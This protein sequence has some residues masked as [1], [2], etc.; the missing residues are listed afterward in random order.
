[1]I[2]AHDMKDKIVSY[3]KA[4]SGKTPAYAE[5]ADL[6]RALSRVVMESLAE[7]WERAEIQ[8]KQGRQAHYFSIEFLTGRSL[9]NNL[10]NLGLYETAAYAV[11]ELGF[12]LGDLIEQ[13]ADPGLGNG[14][15]GR[16]AACF[17]DSCAAGSLPVRGYGILY[18]YGLFRQAIENGFQKEYPDAWMEQP[19]PFLVC[20]NQQKVLVRY[21]DLDVFAVPYDL[22]ITGYRSDRVNTLRLWKAEPILPFDFELFNAQRFDEAVK[23]RNRVQDIC[24][25]LY[26]NDTTFEG[27]LLRVRQQYFFVSASI[28][29]IVNDFIT[30]HGKDFDRF[31][32]YN[33][34]QLNDTHPVLAIPELM[35]ILID[36]EHLNWDQAWRIT[37]KVFAYTNHTIMQE[38]L[39]KW[40]VQIFKCLF[41]RILEII[42]QIDQQFRKDAKQ[43]GLSEDQIQCL[44]PQNDGK[45]QM[46]S[47]A[48][49]G[50]YSVNGVA[51]MHTRI[52]KQQTL[53]GFYQLWPERFN[54][55]TNGVTPRRWLRVC[56]PELSDLLTT[57]SGGDKWL[58][59]LDRLEALK[60][61]V[62]DDA[63]M[64]RL[65]SIKQHS[66]EKLARFIEQTEHIDIDPSFIFDVQIKRL[67]E[68]KRQLLNA[69]L[70]LD[71]YF[72]IRENPNN[73][74]TPTVYLFGA[75]AAPG[76][77]KAKAIIK[78]INEIARLVNRDPAVNR[79]MKVVFLPNYNVSLAE[80]IFPAADLSEQISTVGKEASGTGNMKFMMNGAVT[81]GTNDGANV[82]IAEAAGYENN[83]L[84]GCCI[85]DFPQTIGY[86]DPQW[87]YEHIPGLKRCVD[88]LVD[89]TFD[90]GGTGLFQD[91]YH[92]LLYGSEFQKADP[93]Y[94]LGDFD[95]YRKTRHRV[96]K[97]YQDQLAFA[98]KRWQNITSSGRFS[99]D[100]TIR[101][102]ADEIWKIRPVP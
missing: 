68:Y 94:V 88:T 14:G 95:E 45:I 12:D 100:R 38:A 25:V 78:F 81:L 3:L 66:K 87:Q 9:A 70:I 32:E 35:R 47:L 96:Q 62:Q 102:Y 21:Q 31:A 59:D 34:I 92:G 84:F 33:A 16:L 101:E 80:K 13:E 77:F 28:Q 7:Q 50:S 54:N 98:R 75:K 90:D 18:R 39:E 11:K 43:R 65:I 41:P 49:Y 86:Y 73:V 56:N 19:Y 6:W 67:H 69:L 79:F 23:E 24:R 76:Y 83:Y 71:D 57:L 74:I 61:L 26:P 58:T 36:V 91:L 53:S 44:A 82:E 5:P 4:E 99:S 48:V 20:R 29:S 55:K 17:L 15:L 72:R 42:Q 37:Q 40:D 27:K 93:Y 10:I 1:M 46:A 30:I 60:P 85:E 97:D 22:P 64:R 52:L 8:Y 63:V 89:G 51:E 2:T